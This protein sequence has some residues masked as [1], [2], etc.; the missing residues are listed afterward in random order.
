MLYDAM[1]FVT[2]TTGVVIDDAPLFEV[3]WCME[4]VIGCPKVE[5]NPQW[6]HV[7]KGWPAIAALLSSS[8][9]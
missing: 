2:G 8:M 1:C 3:C 4:E 7:D 6:L 5:A 9:V